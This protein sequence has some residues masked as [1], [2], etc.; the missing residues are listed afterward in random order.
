MKQNDF[1]IRK[2]EDYASKILEMNEKERVQFMDF[3]VNVALQNNERLIEMINET[4]ETNKFLTS[5]VKILREK[6][7]NFESFIRDSNLKS[8]YKFYSRGKE[9]I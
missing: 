7:E 9:V 5:E 6:I 1:V 4:N 3:M 2:L 8:R